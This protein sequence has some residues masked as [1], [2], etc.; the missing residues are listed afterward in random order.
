MTARK[1]SDAPTDEAPAEAAAIKGDVEEKA[2][3]EV[4]QGFVGVKV[5][6]RDDAEYTLTT[7]PSSPP[8]V[9]DDRTRCDQPSKE[10]PHA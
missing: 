6:P 5:D 1:D 4:E 8:A 10:I 7:G 9:P 2:R 3:V